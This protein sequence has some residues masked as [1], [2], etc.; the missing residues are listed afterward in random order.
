[1]E[2]LRAR[3]T[4]IPLKPASHVLGLARATARRRLAPPMQRP[5]PA[6]PPSPRKLTEP[7]RQAVLEGL[8]S[9]RFQD[10][11]PRQVYA[12]LLDEGTYLATPR[13]M[14]RLLAA[15][16]ELRERRDQR[17]PRSHAIPRLV[18]TK[19]HEVWSWDIS[20]LATYTPGVFLNL[21]L[22]LDLFSRYPVAWM[23][24]ERENSALAKQLIGD[25]IARYEVAPG[26][27]TI[28]ND[29]GAPM[30]SLG[31][32]DLLAELGVRRS[33]SRPRVSNDNPVLGGLLQDRQ[34]SARLPG[35]LPRRRPHP[36][37]VRGLLPL[38]HPSAP[39]VWPRSFHICRRLLRPSASGRPQATS[40]PQRRL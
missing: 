15:E 25:A 31:F 30:T 12:E 35:P 28:H 4:V 34:V 16:G 9:E 33:A 36:P 38:V 18:A 8:H 19:P 6:P 10:Q 21:Y 14:Y 23:V 40:G 27:V 2:L 37:L 32:I 5:Q 39:L 29:R 26:S 1:M 22:V 3:D 13:T 11:P 17:A 20:K 7:E 24:A